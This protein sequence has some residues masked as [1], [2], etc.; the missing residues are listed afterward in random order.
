MIHTGILQNGNIPIA[1]ITYDTQN[2][3]IKTIKIIDATHMPI[4]TVFDGKIKPFVYE[5]LKNRS[6]PAERQN[7]DKVLEKLNIISRHELANQSFGLS[8]SDQ[9]WINPTNLFGK[10]ILKWEDVNFFNNEFSHDVGDLFFCDKDAKNISLV[11]PIN[12]SDGVL[13]KIWVISNEE[14]YLLKAGDSITQ[15]EPFNEVIASRIL[16]HM[17]FENYVPY[18]LAYIDSDDGV[19]PVSVCKCFCDD[20]TESVPL[21]HVLTSGDAMCIPHPFHFNSSLRDGLE[22]YNCDMVDVKRYFDNMNVLDYIIM[23][24]D[25]HLNNICF[26]RDINEPQSIRLGPIFDS[27]NS[28]FYSISEINN[29]TLQNYFNGPMSHYHG[30]NTFEKFIE[31]IDPNNVNIN[32]LY[33]I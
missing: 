24:K 10:P 27:G 8:L 20:H 3:E 29:E 13:K 21:S 15:Q 28:L 6:I 33:G 17:G 2:S 16:E 5:M 7:L 26:L 19:I 14:R 18:E 9:Y 31:R 23:N 30:F 11:D 4:N 22:L 12:T 32:T 1:K 25:R